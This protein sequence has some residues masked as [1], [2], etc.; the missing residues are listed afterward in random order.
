TYTGVG[1]VE[2][3]SPLRRFFYALRFG[4]LKLFLSSDVTKESRILYYRDIKERVLKIAPFLKLDRDPYLVIAEG[5]MYWILDAY[6][7]TDRYPYSQQLSLNGSPSTSL[8]VNYIRNSVKAVVDAYDGTIKLYQADLDDPIIRTYAKIFP[9]TFRELE[10]MPKGLISHIRYPEDIFTLQTAIYTTYHMD[11]PQIFYNK[12]DQWEIPAI[13]TSNKEQTG[14]RGES[15]APRHLIMKL[16]GEK[17]E[18]YILMLPFTPRAKDNLSAWMVARN[19]GGQYGKLVVYRF[20]KD[21]LVF[22]PKQVIG[23]I[24]QD[25]EVSRQISLWDQRGSQVI[26]GPLLVIPI[27]ESLVYVRPLYLKAEAGKIP[28]LKRVIVAY[29]NKIAM[30]ETLEAGLAK[31]FGTAEGGQAKPSGVSA[32]IAPTGEADMTKEGL[33]QQATQSYE[34]AIRAQREGDWGRYGEEIK[35]LGEILSKLSLRSSN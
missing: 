28:E 29:E 20:P 11:D 19:D 5:K 25:A 4:S 34:A 30:E 14:G 35:R 17:A 18:E 22:G 1:G 32:R 13:S 15:M 31:I 7:S 27:E 3:N 26:Q 33:L 2:I 24:N 10:E 9:K 8:R 6:T 16:P 21:K 23:R 12:E